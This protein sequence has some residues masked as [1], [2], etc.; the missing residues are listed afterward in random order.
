MRLTAFQLGQTA[1]REGIPRASNPFP[2]PP[3]PVQGDDYPG[4]WH[5]WDAGW[6][7]ANATAAHDKARST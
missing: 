3:A 5:N 1:A 4:P 2:K 7:N 6:Y